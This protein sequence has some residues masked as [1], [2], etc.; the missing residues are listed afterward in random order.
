MK[1]ILALLLALVMVLGLAAC[2]GTEGDTELLGM[3]ASPIDKVALTVDYTVPEDF[4][5]GFICLHSEE[6]TYD[7]NF[8]NAV[9]EIKQAANLTDDQVIIKTNIAEGNECY[10]A[11]KDLA[12]AGCDIVFANSFGHEDFMIKAAQE[13]PDRSRRHI[14][15]APSRR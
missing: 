6:S 1:K 12:D 5:I 10:V 13:F 11:A 9:E 4:K 8:L 14:F 7:L 3:S 2:G 15:D